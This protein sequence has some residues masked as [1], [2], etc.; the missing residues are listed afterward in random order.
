MKEERTNLL[1]S[2]KE[3]NTSN[4]KYY[5]ENAA[6]S[7]KLGFYIH[8]SLRGKLLCKGVFYILSTPQAC[9]CD[10]SL[11]HKCVYNQE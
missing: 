3:R 8:F 2:E 10:I 6:L 1:K 11:H 5:K 4:T 9:F 7:E